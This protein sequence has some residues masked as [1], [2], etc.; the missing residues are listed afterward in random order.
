VGAGTWSSTTREEISVGRVR[1]AG[2]G[3]PVRGPSSGSG[4]ARAFKRGAGGKEPGGTVR[5]WSRSRRKQAPVPLFGII[6]REAHR[7]DTCAFS[8]ETLRRESVAHLDAG[9]VCRWSG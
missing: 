4:R 3:H 9:R 8:D 5:R 2:S 1:E 6:S 7:T